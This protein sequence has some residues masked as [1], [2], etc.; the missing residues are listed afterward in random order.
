MDHEKSNGL[1]SVIVP[2][3]KAEKYLP[4]C[5][6]SI[7][8]QTYGNLEIVLVDDGSPD[9]CGD[10]CDVYA[11]NDKRIKVIHQENAGV[12]AARNAGLDA[13]TG[14]FVLFVDSDDYIDA[15]CIETCLDVMR[16]G[17]VDAVCF[18][19]CKII[20]GKIVPTTIYTENMDTNQIVDC[21]LKES[22]GI[23]LILDKLYRACVW[24]NLRFP[25]GLKLEDAIL[26]PKVL[27]RSKKIIPLERYFYFYDCDNE[28]SIMHTLSYDDEYYYFKKMEARNIFYSG[29]DKAVAEEFL[30]KAMQHALKCY[31]A[32]IYLNFLR[33]EFIEDI[34]HFLSSNASMGAKLPLVYRIYLGGLK[35]FSLINKIK[36]IY[37][38]VKY[39]SRM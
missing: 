11:A 34:T 2:V 12:S 32:N 19:L 4:R 36:G 7:V 25:V 10:I 37:Y 9:K 13:M 16:N 22:K 31:N 21:L 18:N 27:E 20:R 26:L 39:R 29:K 23:C 38:F 35:H 8:Q 3:Y 1:V 30:K 17:E 24:K 15:T 28:N 14:Q 5:I 33:S 6:K